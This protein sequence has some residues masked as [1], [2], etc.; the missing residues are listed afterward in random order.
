MV[1]LPSTLTRHPSQNH[2]WYFAILGDTLHRYYK[3]AI[4]SFKL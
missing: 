1:K 3:Q 2:S 4:I